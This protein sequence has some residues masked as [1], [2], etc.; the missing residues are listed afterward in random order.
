MASTFDKDGTLRPSPSAVVHSAGDAPTEAAY[1]LMSVVSA[2]ENGTHPANF[3]EPQGTSVTP[4]HPQQIVASDS[5][6]D[7]N[8]MQFYLAQ[9]P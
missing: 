2:E 6:C 9:I 5:K 4:P 7:V 1:Q 8:A 3:T